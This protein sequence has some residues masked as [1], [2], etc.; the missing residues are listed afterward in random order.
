MKSYFKLFYTIFVLTNKFAI[1]VDIQL[2]C[3]NI[4]YF[5]IYHLQ[6]VAT[7]YGLINDQSSIHVLTEILLEISDIK[8]YRQ[9]DNLVNLVENMSFDE[10]LNVN[11]E[12]TAADSNQIQSAVPGNQSVRAIH[13]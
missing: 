2:K 11:L 3:N 4:V 7:V 6:F 8:Y 10:G 9:L 5:K 1:W 12:E 13:E